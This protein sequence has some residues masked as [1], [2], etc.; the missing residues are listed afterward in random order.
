MMGARFR[1]GI[2]FPQVGDA[3]VRIEHVRRAEL[4]AAVT[5]QTRSVQS[6]TGKLIPKRQLASTRLKRVRWEEFHEGSLGGVET[7]VNRPE[8]ILT[9]VVWYHI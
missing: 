3:P 7:D 9:G 5:P 1:T 8:G 4:A 6:S 2:P